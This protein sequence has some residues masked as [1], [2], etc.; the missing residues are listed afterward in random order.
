MKK[1]LFSY[2]DGKRDEYL[3]F[4]ED[5]CNIESPTCF[6]SGVDEV[7]RYFIGKAR[8]K[9]WDVQVYRQEKSGDLVC[10][11]LAPDASNAPVFFSA[12]LDTVHPL[13][14]F[15]QP[16][17]KTDSE[18]IYGPGVV[19]CK[20]GAVAAFLAM[21]ALDAAGYRDRPVKLLLQTDEEGGSE[22]SG[23]ATIRKMCELAKGAEAFIN[24]EGYVRGQVCVIRKGIV[25]YT[26]NIKGIAAHS[27]MCAVDGASAIA[28]A[29]YKII[30]LE[31]LKDDK[32]IT[33]NCGIIKGGS[34]P[35]TVADACEFEANIRF[36]TPEQLE[37]VK[38]YV[39]RVSDTVHVP[40]CSC[41]LTVKSEREAMPECERNLALVDR[42][43]RAFEEY[44]LPQLKAVKENYGSDAAEIT[45]WAETPCVDSLG[46][47]G[48]RIHSREEFAFISSLYEA[49]KRMAAISASL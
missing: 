21:D 42:M 12:H 14:L 31:K 47:E 6:K 19:D 27:S 16:A 9:G 46:V 45:V 29:A 5:V 43:N 15:G 49:A 30:E 13:G 18:R 3:A 20:G 44:G 41:E 8:E 2:I 37:W 24:L 7:G 1:R 48:G 39:R 17:V 32:G 26:F 28:E 11:T 33:C 23:K 40:G 25:S 35:N 4:W 38:E 36:A 22:L 34:A 10:I